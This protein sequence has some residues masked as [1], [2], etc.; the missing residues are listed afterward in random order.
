MKRSINWKRVRTVFW[1]GFLITLG[2]FICAIAINGILIPKHFVSGGLTGISLIV[3]YFFDKIDVGWLYLIFNIPLFI[4][5]WMRVSRQF[6]L[7]SLFGVGVF[8]L[9]LMV[10][11]VTIAV[12]DQILA[13]ILGGIIAGIGS[14]I[15]FRSYGSAGGLDII[16]IFLNQKYSIRLGQT[17][18]ASNS[19]I[20]LAC[21]ILFGIDLALY[22][23]VYIF[24]ATYVIDLVLVGLNQRETVFIISDNPKEIAEEILKRMNRGVTFFKGEGAYTHTPRDIIYTAITMRELTKLKDLIFSVDKDAFVVVNETKEVL[25]R[26]HEMRKIY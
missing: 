11:K 21:A 15:I 9:A 3:Y 18:L 8:S 26:G 23:L 10:T 2:S 20:L 5:G 13:A 25:G 17:I 7:Y 14:G 24:V 4:M 22:T 12:H 1:N 6:F 16:S 19:I